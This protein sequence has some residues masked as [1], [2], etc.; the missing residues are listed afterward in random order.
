[1]SFHTDEAMLLLCDVPLSSA[2]DFELDAFWTVNNA[3][4]PSNFIAQLG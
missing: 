3:Q 2:T 1:V 4:L